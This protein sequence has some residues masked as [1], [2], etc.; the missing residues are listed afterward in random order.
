MPASC[1]HFLFGLQHFNV[2]E[3][4]LASF[5]HINRK[6]LYMKKTLLTLL[7]ATLLVLVTF[8]DSSAQKKRFFGQVPPVRT[9]QNG[10]G[11]NYPNTTNRSGRWNSTRSANTNTNNR[12]WRNRDGNRDDDRNDDR[13]ENRKQNKKYYKSNNGKHK[14]WYKNNNGHGNG[15]HKD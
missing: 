8:S 4:N 5:C 15:H 6:N 1:R 11:V 13:Y 9:N 3:L 12:V 10:V 2:Q 7:S 14:G